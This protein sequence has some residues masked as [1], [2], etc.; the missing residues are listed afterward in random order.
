MFVAKVNEPLFGGEVE[1]LGRPGPLCVG[2]L[3][4]ERMRAVQSPELSAVA[5]ELE[6]VVE[7]MAL[8]L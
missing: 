8:S 7:E 3:V 1:S 4:I 5:D 2:S 6:I